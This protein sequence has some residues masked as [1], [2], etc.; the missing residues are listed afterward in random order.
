MSNSRSDNVKTAAVPQRETGG[1]PSEQVVGSTPA[2][3]LSPK[4]R[5]FVALSLGGVTTVI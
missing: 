1:A 5:N 3:M 4:A 2:V